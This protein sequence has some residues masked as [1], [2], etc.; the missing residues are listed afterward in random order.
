MRIFLRKKGDFQVF[1][2]LFM[3]SVRSRPPGPPAVPGVYDMID[4]GEEMEEAGEEKT[5]CDGGRN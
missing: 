4:I 2:K 1:F 5:E 3:A